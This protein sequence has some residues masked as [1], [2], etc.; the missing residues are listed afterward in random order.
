VGTLA[1]AVVGYASIRW[2]LR[3][4]TSH[5]LWPF[6]VYRLGLAGVLAWTLGSSAARS[7]PS[8]FTFL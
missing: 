5:T 2:L 4:L 8:L 1:A 3:V 7:I 6:I